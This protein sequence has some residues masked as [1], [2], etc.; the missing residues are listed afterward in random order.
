MSEFAERLGFN[1]PDPLT[2]YIKLFT[3]FLKC[4]CTPVIQPEPQP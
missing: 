3:H 2:G 4:P 1:L